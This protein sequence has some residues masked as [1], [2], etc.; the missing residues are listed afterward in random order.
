M[1]YSFI[2]CYFK[3]YLFFFFFYD[4]SLLFL[5]YLLTLYYTY[6]IFLGIKMSKLI[7]SLHTCL[8]TTIAVFNDKQKLIN[9]YQYDNSNTIVYQ[10]LRML[11]ELDEVDRHFCFLQGQFEEMFLLYKD[12]KSK[13]TLI[14]G[15]WRTNPINVD[16]LNNLTSS[17]K[18]QLIEFLEKLPIFFLNDIEELLT[19]VHFC[20]SKEESNLL[21]FPL[22]HYVQSLLDNECY[23]VSSY[24]LEENYATYDYIYQQE[25]TVLQCVRSGD[26]EQLL[27]LNS[28][29]SNFLSVPQTGN[30][31][32]SE[33]NFS[34]ILC[35]KLSSVSIEV[36]MNFAKAYHIRNMF[37]KKIEKSQT[38][39]QVAKNRAAAFVYFTH[40]IGKLNSKTSLFQSPFINAV[41][42]YLY[43]NLH[44][45][46]S[47]KEVASHFNIS[48][49][50]LRKD[51]KAVTKVTVK[52]Y[53]F[54]LKIKKAMEMLKSGVKVE[55]TAL[56]LGFKNVSHFS[57]VFKSTTK[58][59]P[60]Q[61]QIQS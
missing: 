19:L 54:N 37:V 15:P 57:R 32:R 58:L 6:I 39:P 47:T 9:H 26:T 5:F 52:D 11:E 36:G 2:F 60:K 13:L 33:K 61:F 46:L 10:Y 51:F 7:K 17:Y 45:K 4:I 38:L 16:N 12:K 44:Q 23:Q 41:I 27:H 42:H 55:D 43:N 30:S 29:L 50:K 59:S 53:F 25:N 31:L 22:Q 20:F 35:E 18:H 14:I 40:E 48:E 24:L 1:F 56:A 3:I 34:I 49:S 21:E 28:D 8:K